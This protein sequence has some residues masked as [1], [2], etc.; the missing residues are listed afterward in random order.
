MKLLEE[1][2]DL[3]AERSA[4]VG[5]KLEIRAAGRIPGLHQEADG[6]ECGVGKSRHVGEI[7]D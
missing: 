5:E 4:E 3:W 7:G 1:G 2:V 6:G